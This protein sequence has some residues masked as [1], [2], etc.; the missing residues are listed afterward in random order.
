MAERRVCLE[1]FRNLVGTTPRP[2]D[3]PICADACY[4]AVYGLPR[5][6]CLAIGEKAIQRYFPIFYARQPGGVR[7]MSQA[8]HKLR[9]REPYS[10]DKW[11]KALLW[12]VEW[13]T[14]KAPDD[15]LFLYAL[16]AM[17]IVL[18]QDLAPGPLAALVTQ[19]LMGCVT[20]R[21][22]NVSAA[23]QPVLDALF[24]FEMGG[25]DDGM[26]AD[27]AAYRAREA[28]RE[29]NGEEAARHA[30][31]ARKLRGVE[32]GIRIARRSVWS[33]FGVD[34]PA[35]VTAWR[36]L[37]ITLGWLRPYGSKYP[38]VEVHAMLRDREHLDRDSWDLMA[39]EEKRALAAS[40]EC[41]TQ[42]A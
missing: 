10:A 9:E 27:A 1:E 3:E 24:R 20:Q 42:D 14:S 36:E 25:L 33:Q 39:E 31:E 11:P 37:R 34:L 21:R 32:Q 23:D 38:H 6:A 41:T 12:F 5:E 35:G 2:V 29:G 7:A 13:R 16:E 19:T 30:R 40:G 4:G 8:E 26:L 22:Q 17:H 18:R 28:E 15:M